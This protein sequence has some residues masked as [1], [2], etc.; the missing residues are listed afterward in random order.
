MSAQDGAPRRV[1]ATV[2]IRTRG[3]LCGACPYLDMTFGTCRLFYEAVEAE[4]GEP[5]RCPECLA[6]DEPERTPEEAMA[7]GLGAQD[8]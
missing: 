3:K 6:L 7:H 1:L 8:G 5:L 4:E 2:E